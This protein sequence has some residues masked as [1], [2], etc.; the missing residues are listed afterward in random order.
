MNKVILMGRLTKEPEMRQT[1]QGVSVC[2]FSIAVN[3]RFAKEGQMNADFIN[4]TAWRNTADF[5]SKY[6]HKGN[7]IAVVG[8]LQTSTWEGQ[9][10]KKQYSTDV[11]VDEA[12]FTG[13]KENSSSAPQD[14]FGGFDGF[15]EMD[16]TGDSFPWEN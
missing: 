8:S 4:C 1:P 13:S 2:R 11:L 7:M 12:Y 5:I 6:F 3:R 15:K 16:A 9:D 14:T 10:G